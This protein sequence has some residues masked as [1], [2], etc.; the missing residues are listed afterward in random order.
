VRGIELLNFF[1]SYIL[2]LCGQVSADTFEVNWYLELDRKLFAVFKSQTFK[3]ACDGSTIDVVHC[4]DCQ[5]HI[6]Q[7]AQSRGASIDGELGSNDQ[8]CARANQH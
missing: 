8:A 6:L 5:F 3:V 4:G 1:G 7:H 2:N